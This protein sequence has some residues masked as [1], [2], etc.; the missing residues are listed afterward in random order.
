ML[1]SDMTELPRAMLNKTQTTFF[2][3]SK[4]VTRWSFAVQNSRDTLR[5]FEMLCSDSLICQ[6]S[7]SWA[8]IKLLKGQRG[9]RYLPPAN[10]KA[11]LRVSKEQTKKNRSKKR[12]GILDRLKRS[13]LI[14]LGVTAVVC[15]EL[16][17]RNN[18]KQSRERFSFTEYVKS[19]PSILICYRYH[20]HAACLWSLLHW[21]L[22]PAWVDTLSE[23]FYMWRAKPCD[24]LHEPYA[25]KHCWV[26][27]G[28]CLCC[29]D[30]TVPL[31]QCVF[32]NVLI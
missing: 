1:V 9:F 3:E 5:L 29:P 12:R 6:T 2:P 22:C 10:W 30:C 21:F 28:L 18:R 24:I 26:T 16:S 19:W 13:C 32:E 25:A 27:A 14:L 31:T 4:K 11:E 23:Q 15:G 20:R 7:T 8:R 17:V